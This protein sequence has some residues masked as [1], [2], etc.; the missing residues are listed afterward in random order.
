MRGLI[1][2]SLKVFGRYPNVH[3]ELIIFRR[4]SMT[5]GSTSFSSL[6]GIGSNI[7]VVGL[8]YLTSLYNSS[9]PIEENCSL[10]DL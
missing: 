8:D 1:T 9:F 3:D 7:H 10:G 2:A 6:D 5:F 4:G